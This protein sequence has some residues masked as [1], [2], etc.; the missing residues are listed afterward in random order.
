MN[1]QITK[2][3]DSLTICDNN[4]SHIILWPI[5]QDVINM[6]LVMDGNEE[7]LE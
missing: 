4:G 3:K 1:Y 6:A 2:T 5:S 7:T